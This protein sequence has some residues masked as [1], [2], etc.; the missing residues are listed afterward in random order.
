MK[1]VVCALQW[2]LPACGGAVLFDLEE[3]EIRERKWEEEKQSWLEVGDLSDRL[4]RLVLC[5]RGQR[6]D[7]ELAFC[8]G[9]NIFSHLV[10]YFCL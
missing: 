5:S 6:S 9:V 3:A 1:L 2:P 10:P 8:M 4:L 7:L